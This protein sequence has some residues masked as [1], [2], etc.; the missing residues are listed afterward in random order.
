MLFSHESYISLLIYNIYCILLIHES[1]N[2]HGDTVGPST[3]DRK[4]VINNHI[5]KSKCLPE[6]DIGQAVV[7]CEVW[8]PA[9]AP[10]T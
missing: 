2:I 3:P 8:F 4:V 9:I 10:D 6:S 7:R 1:H 5:S